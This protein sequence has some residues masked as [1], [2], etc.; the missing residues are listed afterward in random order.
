MTVR[1]GLSVQDWRGHAVDELGD[2][3]S[4][5]YRA[6][7]GHLLLGGGGAAGTACGCAVPGVRHL[8]A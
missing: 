1:W 2:H 8:A 4:G 3:P 7:C 5:V 6:E